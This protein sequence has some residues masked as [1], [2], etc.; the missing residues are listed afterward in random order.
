MPPKASGP[1]RHV[2]ISSRPNRR[3]CA[4]LEQ[5][6]PKGMD[7]LGGD[8]PFIMEADGKC[9]AVRAIGAEG[10]PAADALRAGGEPGSQSA[11]SGQQINPA[12]K[13]WPRPGNEYPCA[14]GSAFPLR[15]HHIPADRV[16]LRRHLHSCDAPH[17]GAATGGFRGD[18]AGVGDELEIRQSG[19]DRAVSTAR[20][21][22]EVK[23]LVT[24]RMRPFSIAGKM[25][26]QV[27]MP[28]VYGWEGY[29]HGAIANV[30]LAI[31]G[32]PNTSIHS[33]KALTCNFRKG[34][35]PRPGGPSHG[36]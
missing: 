2:R 12:A 3:T 27:G 17:R 33:T 14:A 4:R 22:I 19:L 31:H 36:H 5:L 7:A 9:H 20:G 23:A 24:R 28:W 29:A 26:H 11:V 8:D 13:L 6:H 18:L 21:E 32:D 1:A 30:L 15:L 25:V 35:L 34:R 10:W 16:A